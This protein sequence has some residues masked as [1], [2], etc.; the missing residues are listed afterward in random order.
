MKTTLKLEEAAM[1][2]IALYFLSIHDLGL[3]WWIWLLL[4][5]APDLSMLGYLFNNRSGAIF[6]NIFHHKGLAILIIAAGLLLDSELLIATGT[7]LFAHSSFDRMLGYG[8][9]YTTGFK[10]T[11]LG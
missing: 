7:V 5:F 4:F 11:H 8:L 9:K 10:D 1:T 6:Y 2:A 3:S